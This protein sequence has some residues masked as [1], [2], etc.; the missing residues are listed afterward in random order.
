MWLP[1]YKNKKKKRSETVA[2]TEV[3]GGRQEIYRT[4]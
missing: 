3:N 2:I 1:I 4:A